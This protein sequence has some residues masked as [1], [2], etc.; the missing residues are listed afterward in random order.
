MRG[1]KASVGTSFRN[2]KE[3]GGIE[4][5]HQCLQCGVFVPESEAVVATSGAVYCCEEHRLRHAS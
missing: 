3:A 1:K 5:M 2:A 4:M